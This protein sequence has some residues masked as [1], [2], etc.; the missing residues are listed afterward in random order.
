MKI[1]KRDQN[2][3]K[4]KKLGF[5]V[6][7]IVVS[8]MTGRMLKKIEDSTAPRKTNK[9]VQI[10]SQKSV[11][12]MENTQPLT[13][14]FTNSHKSV[15]NFGVSHNVHACG[16]R[17]RRCRRKHG[18]RRRR[19][20]RCGK[21]KKM[22]LKKSRWNPKPMKECGG[23]KQD[24]IEYFFKTEKKEI[25]YYFGPSGRKFFSK[26]GEVKGFTVKIMIGGVEYICKDP[27]PAG[28]QR[29]FLQGDDMRKTFFWKADIK[30]PEPKEIK[31][32]AAIFKIFIVNKELNLVYIIENGAKVYLPKAQAMFLL[33]DDKEKSF[34]ANG[35]TYFFLDSRK[36]RCFAIIDGQKNEYF[37]STVKD[38]GSFVGIDGI[39]YFFTDATKKIAFFLN[40]AGER[41][42]VDPQGIAFFGSFM[43][44]GVKYY[45]TDDKKTK[46]FQVIDGMKIIKEV[47][48]VEA[49]GEFKGND[50][51]VYFFLDAEHSR[52]F[53]FDEKKEM[54]FASVEE[55]GI[56]EIL[57]IPTPFYF[58]V[59]TDMYYYLEDKT[60][61]FKFGEPDK[62]LVVLDIL[63]V[64]GGLFAP[65]GFTLIKEDKSEVEYKFEDL[66]RERCFIFKEGEIPEK[67]EKFDDIKGEKFF[68]WGEMKWFFKDVKTL[69]GSMPKA[70][71]DIAKLVVAEV[72]LAEIKFVKTELE[73]KGEEMEKKREENDKKEEA[74]FKADQAAAE[75]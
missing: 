6:C 51:K 33:G 61:C 27:N 30:E 46:C 55:I 9:R 34:V 22:R 69:K 31:L 53:S 41:I 19:R 48:E 62:E 29:C 14:L 43:A 7:L 44:N 57:P 68:I 52:C 8:V 47:K 73:I 32:G 54:V 25:C 38:N 23:F 72:K 59:G 49:F 10:F 26:V 63:K 5:I 65:E 56:K 74:E 1:S 66:S 16:G 64:E 4:L 35:I 75:E 37:V 13:P 21:W 11:P 71:T 15:A 24:G 67:L 12:P 45:Y 58:F 20:K 70:E 36:D 3:I 42:Y 60:K 17:R 18:R 2:Y 28:K 40:P 39:K 50:D